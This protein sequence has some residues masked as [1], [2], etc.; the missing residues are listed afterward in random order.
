MDDKLIVIVQLIFF[1]ILVTTFI[2]VSYTGKVTLWVKLLLT[3][4]SIGVLCFDKIK[5]LIWAL[6]VGA[7]WLIKYSKKTNTNGRTA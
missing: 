7:I 3:L 6:A 4:S 2:Y 5:L 1:V